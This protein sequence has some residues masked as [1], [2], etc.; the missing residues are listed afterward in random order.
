MGCSGGRVKTYARGVKRVIGR[1][2]PLI[3]GVLKLFYKL[4]PP[5]YRQPAGSDEPSHKT[6]TCNH[7]S[8]KRLPGIGC[9][10]KD[11]KL[12]A[13]R[14]RFATRTTIESASPNGSDEGAEHPAQSE[15]T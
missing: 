13:E 1:P 6:N 4:I 14:C 7:G 2:T 3:N 9:K 5:N 12:Q 11:A 15:P 8:N 10:S